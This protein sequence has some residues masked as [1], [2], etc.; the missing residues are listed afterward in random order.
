MQHLRVE[1]KTDII[2]KLKKLIYEH[3]L[4]SNIV[5]KVKKVFGIEWMTLNEVDRKMD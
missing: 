5:K 1:E 4:M 2:V 3:T